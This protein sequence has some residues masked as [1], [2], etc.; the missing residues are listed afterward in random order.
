MISIPTWVKVTIGFVAGAATGAVVTHLY[1]KETIENTVDR[2]VFEIVGNGKETKTRTELVT[3]EIEAT[4]LPEQPSGLDLSNV[5]AGDVD[6]T[7]FFNAVNA[8]PKDRYFNSVEEATAH[9]DEDD[10]YMEDAK[11]YMDDYTEEY[12]EDLKMKRESE[13]RSKQ[14]PRVMKMDEVKQPNSNTFRELCY[15]PETGI[16]TEF[17]TDEEIED[18]RGLV[19]DLLI[20]SGFASDQ[21]KEGVIFIENNALG[22]WYEITKAY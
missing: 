2:R 20:T 22:E 10:D 6:Y 3:D 19:G 11:E 13:E 9:P 7:A 15:Y 4:K 18:V 14:G 5:S 8:Q 12:L 21:N 1:Y 16:L 17:D